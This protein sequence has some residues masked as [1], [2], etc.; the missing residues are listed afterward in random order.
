MVLVEETGAGGNFEVAE[1]LPD[2][3]IMP[4][5]KIL[6]I[7]DETAIVDNGLF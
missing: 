6:G 7:D 4:L 1:D 3:G 2:P 5:P